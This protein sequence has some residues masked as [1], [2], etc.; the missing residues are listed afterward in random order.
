MR[1]APGATW[2]QDNFCRAWFT[3]REEHLIRDTPFTLSPKNAACAQS[4]THCSF[5]SKG[6]AGGRHRGDRKQED[7]CQGET[8]VAFH[9]TWKLVSTLHPFR[10]S[11]CTWHASFVTRCTPSTSATMAS[12]FLVEAIDTPID[13]IWREAIQRPADSS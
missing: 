4:A 1:E 11:L 6:P 2:C 8:P 5:P 3:E 12:I 7:G 10:T 9:A 13:L